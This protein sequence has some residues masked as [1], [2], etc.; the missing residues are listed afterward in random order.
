MGQNDD[1][2]VASIGSYVRNSFGNRAAAIAPA[3]VARVRAASASRKTPWAIPELE[4][5]L[6]RPIVREPSWKATATRVTAR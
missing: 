5:S 1:E 6:P 3:E 4:S 2:W